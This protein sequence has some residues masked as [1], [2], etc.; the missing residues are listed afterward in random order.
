MTN[1]QERLPSGWTA[2][3]EIDPWVD[4]QAKQERQA[5][6]WTNRR[7]RQIMR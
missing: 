7:G 4:R 6:E 5:D 2:I 1:G 3:G